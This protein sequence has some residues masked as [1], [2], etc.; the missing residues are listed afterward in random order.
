MTSDE[1]EGFF[2]HAVED[3]VFRLLGEAGASAD[4]PASVVCAANVAPLL[5]MGDLSRAVREST[6][7]R[8]AMA[9]LL[10][11]GVPRQ[12]LVASMCW[13]ERHAPWGLYRGTCEACCRPG[14]GVREAAAH[15][16]EVLSAHRERGG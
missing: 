13:L 6:P 7:L 16:R 9:L 5:V 15:L 2:G 12:E 8:G 1:Q 10:E 14:V 4:D 3:T 11:E